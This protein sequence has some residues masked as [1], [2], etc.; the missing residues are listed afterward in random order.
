[1]TGAPLAKVRLTCRLMWRNCASRSGWS[2]PSS[3]FRLPCR[4][5]PP[6]G[7]SWSGVVLPV[8]ERDAFGRHSASPALHSMHRDRQPHL[9]L[10][11]RQVTNCPL[12]AVVDALR[13]D[14]AAPTEVIRIGSALPNPQR[15]PR[16][17]LIELVAVD[18][19]PSKSQDPTI[20]S[21]I[22]VVASF[23]MA[24]QERK[25]STM[26]DA[27]Q[28]IPSFR[29]PSPF[30]SETGLSNAI[31]DEFER[32]STTPT[33]RRITG[34]GSGGPDPWAPDARS[35]N[36]WRSADPSVPSG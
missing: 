23:P 27:L 15:E 11:P 33:L 18:L 12:L 25:F 8:E 34:L 4:L 24:S 19:V 21:G 2:S 22:S 28:E 31:H 14:P 30:L 5:Y 17:A 13:A 16:L 9:P 32:H 10:A 7:A 20:S 1:M 6:R 36:C 35:R 26:D 3:V 29:P